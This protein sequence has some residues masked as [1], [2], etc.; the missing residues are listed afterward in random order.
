MPLNC[1]SCASL[2]RAFVALAANSFHLSYLLIHQTQQS[3]WDPKDSYPFSNYI[4]TMYVEQ[5]LW[6]ICHLKDF[7]KC[8]IFFFFLYFIVIMRSC[9]SPDVA[10]TSMSPRT[11]STL[12]ATV[13]T[14]LPNKDFFSS[15]AICPLAL[16]VRYTRELA[17]PMVALH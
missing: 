2:W 3:E 15:G 17:P 16:L 7:K 6:C 4:E 11:S 12:T 13:P 14:W 9:C 10:Y 5:I 8:L 1:H